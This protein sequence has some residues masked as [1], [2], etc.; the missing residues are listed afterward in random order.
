MEGDPACARE[1]TCRNCETISQVP[2]SFHVI[3]RRWAGPSLLAMIAFETFGQHQ[4]LNRQAERYAKEGVPLSLSTLADHGAICAVMQPIFE[5][6]EAHVLGGERLHGDDTIV[7]VLAKGKTDSGR[8]WTYVGDDPP[9]GRPA[10]PAAVF[11]SSRDRRGE[12]P[13]G[14]PAQWSGV[15][16]ADAYGGNDALYRVAAAQAI[17]IKPCVGPIADVSSSSWRTSLRPP[18]ASRGARRRSSVSVV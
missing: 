1:V 7:P 5:R 11:Y 2:A 13:Q 16:Q 17:S 9:F 8:C 3:A 18:D 14:H 6:I 4:P 10:P 15:L 12:H